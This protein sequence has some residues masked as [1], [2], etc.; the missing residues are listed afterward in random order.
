MKLLQAP[1]CAWPP[2][3]LLFF[4]FSHPCF[5]CCFLSLQPHIHHT[6]RNTNEPYP[7]ACTERSPRQTLGLGTSAVPEGN[8]STCT[9]SVICAHPFL[10]IQTLML[11]GMQQVLSKYLHTS[12]HCSPYSPG[13]MVLRKH[14]SFLRPPEKCFCIQQGASGKSYLHS[15]QSLRLPGY[16]CVHTYSPRYSVA[17][18]L[19]L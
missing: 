3:Y 11:M 2:M 13:C 17:L 9:K 4:F 16:I 12:L 5:C 19:Y 8:V 7:L 6:N 10:C 1:C 14:G 18:I 15:K